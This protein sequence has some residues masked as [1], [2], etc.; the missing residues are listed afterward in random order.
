VD[1]EAEGLRRKELLYETASL[2]P[3]LDAQ[4]IEA[5]GDYAGF[6]LRL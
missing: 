5:K 4:I 1:G 3:M 6:G 2:V